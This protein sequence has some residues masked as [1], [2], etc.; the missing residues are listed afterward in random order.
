MM[1]DL[2]Q[3]YPVDY[4][5]GGATQNTIRV[6]QWLLQVKDAT[7]YIGCVGKD[8]YADKMRDACAKDGVN[9]REWLRVPA[10]CIT[11]TT[12]TIPGGRRHPNRHVRRVHRRPRALP[13]RQ[14]RRGQQLQG[15]VVFHTQC[16]KPHHTTRRST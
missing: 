11:D 5:A 9:V 13:G 15:T 4:I 10:R 16:N 8:D 3:N 7:S 6:A 1:Q 12:G 2:V 14:P